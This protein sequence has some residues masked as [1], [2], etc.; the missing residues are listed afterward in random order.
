MMKKQGRNA[1]PLTQPITCGVE[2]QMGLDFQTVGIDRVQLFHK[3]GE[4]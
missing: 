2:F 3:T 1:E 4:Y